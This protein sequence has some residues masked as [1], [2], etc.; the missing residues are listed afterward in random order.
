[1]QRNLATKSFRT[2]VQLTIVGVVLAL[3][4]IIHVFRD[5]RSLPCYK[6]VD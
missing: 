4:R 2:Q 5:K 1:M 3:A 6:Q